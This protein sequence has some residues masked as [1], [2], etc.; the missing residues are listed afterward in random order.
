[1]QPIASGRNDVPNFILLVC[2]YMLQGVPFGMLNGSLPFLLTQQ[3]QL[4]S[5]TTDPLTTTAATTAAAAAGS[6]SIARG[7]SLT[8]VG[9]LSLAAYPFALKLGWAPLVDSFYSP[10]FGRRKS[11]IV[12]CTVASGIVSDIVLLLYHHLSHSSIMMTCIDV[13]L[14]K[15]CYRR[16]TRNWWE[17]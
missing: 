2:L 8:Q 7:A 14:S 9:L 15:Y 3:S 16:T 6:A 4:H 5:S 17:I 10:S 12:P 1:M 11:W 13:W